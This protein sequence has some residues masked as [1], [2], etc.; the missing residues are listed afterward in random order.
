MDVDLPLPF[1]SQPILFAKPRTVHIANSIV[2]ATLARRP[3]V[4]EIDETQ[5]LVSEIEIAVA[6]KEC[7]NGRTVQAG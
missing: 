1:D 2:P 3:V 5:G 6:R 4:I 7:A